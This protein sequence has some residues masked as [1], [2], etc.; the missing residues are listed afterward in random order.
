MSFFS[1]MSSHGIHQTRYT[2]IPDSHGSDQRNTRPNSQ[3]ASCFSNCYTPLWQLLTN[4]SS[5]HSDLSTH[6]KNA[7][8]SAI[9]LAAESFNKRPDVNE[10]FAQKLSIGNLDVPSVFKEGL[11]KLSELTRVGYSPSAGLPQAKEAAVS[12]LNTIGLPTD[13]LSPDKNIVMANGGTGV[14]ELLILSTLDRNEK[15]G[16][17]SPAYAN[18]PA[19]SKGILNYEVESIP[20]TQDQ[21]T[22]TYTHPPLEE[23]RQFVKDKKIKTLIVETIS[24]PTGLVMTPEYLEGLSNIMKDVKGGWLITDEAYATMTMDAKTNAASGLTLLE[25][26]PG[27]RVGVA[28]SF[29]KFMKACG[30]RLGCLVSTRED[31]IEAVGK[32]ASP[33]L[34]PNVPAQHVL[35]E[36]MKAEKETPVIKSR[37]DEQQ[38]NYKKMSI[39]FHETLSKE[40]KDIV[41]S[42]PDG[43]IYV[44]CNFNDPQFNSEEFSNFCAKEGKVNFHSILCPHQGEQGKEKEYGTVLSAP[45]TGFYHK[46]TPTTLE[47]IT[48]CLYT[49]FSGVYYGTSKPSEQNPGEKQ[50]RIS[51]IPGTDTAFTAKLLIQLNKDYMEA[52]SLSP[53]TGSSYQEQLVPLQEIVVHS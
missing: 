1:P 33:T 48:N 16:V 14:L 27:A 34:G 29:S 11:Q 8:H 47:T 17:F 35:V 12:L 39:Q 36:Q 52:K 43:A 45:M 21:S 7:E 20:I 24:N 42:K 22:A 25:K 49:C 15:I 13:H 31:L 28:I 3:N 51:L 32:V 2:Q 23:V 6:A 40:T 26:D 41:C 18:V 37:I 30:L 4:N 53:E 44:V 50:I 46:N 9:R 5:S 10:V 38:R 19:V